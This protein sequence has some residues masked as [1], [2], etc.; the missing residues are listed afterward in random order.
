MVSV[1]KLLNVAASEVGYEESGGPSGHDGN[2]TKFWAALDPSLQGSPW[3][4]GFVS[5]VFETAGKPLPAID[6]PWGYSYCPDAEVWAKKHDLWS[7]SGRYSPGDIIL[8]CFDGSGVA[9]HTGIVVVDHGSAGVETIEGNTLPTDG[10]DQADGGGVY[11]KVRPHGPTILGVIESHRW[12]GASAI[13]HR[14]PKPGTPKHNP[15]AG[16][17]A[18][19]HSGDRGDQ[20]RFVQWAESIPVDGV[21][22]PQTVKATRL[23]QAHHPACG[24]VDGVVGPKTLAVLKTRTH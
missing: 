3:C 18:D 20:V 6:H 15:Y 19:C 17:A 22:G 13:I 24:A 1:S 5:W 9:E 4:A 7:A 2:V 12:L 10:G 16:H 11:R 23:F 14:T 21:Y 8:Y